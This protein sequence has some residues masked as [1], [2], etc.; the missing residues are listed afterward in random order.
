M[1]GKTYRRTTK[2]KDRRSAEI[3]DEAHRVELIEKVFGN[4]KKTITIK[5]A[6]DHFLVYKNACSTGQHAYI[7]KELKNKQIHK[8][9]THDL[10]KFVLAMRALD[11]KERSIHQYLSH[12]KSAINFVKKQKYEVNDDLEYPELKIKKNQVKIMSLQEEDKL[13][14]MLDPKRDIQNMN[15]FATRSKQVQKE[16]QDMYDLTVMLIDTGARLTEITT[17]KWDQIDLEKGTIHL[18]RSKVNNSSVLQLTTR[19]INL[20]KNKELNKL[21]KWVFNSREGG[22]RLPPNRP[23]RKALKTIDPLLTIH[24][25]RHIY[26]S[27]LIE[28]GMSIYEISTILGH[29]HTT[30]TEHYAHLNAG[31]ASAKAASIL[32][33]MQERVERDKIHDWVEY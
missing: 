4:K 9:T 27:K 28:Q 16:V 15:K 31:K 26:A 14:T 11:Y 1:G 21:N 32:N 23:L 19:C 10:V 6:M 24:S 17:L 5:D 13:L 7:I 12:I 22:H 20:L 2:T 18:Y 8:I 29:S 33:D 25:L 30:M 3:V